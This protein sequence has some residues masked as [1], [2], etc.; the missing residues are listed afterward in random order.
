M[1]RKLFGSLWMSLHVKLFV[2][3]KKKFSAILVQLDS[4][5]KL[6]FMTPNIKIV[7]N[8]FLITN[9]IASM[10]PTAAHGSLPDLPSDFII[11]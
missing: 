3:K 11:Y 4:L 9:I 6:L 2:L 1:I 7:V 10:F 8:N 5:Q